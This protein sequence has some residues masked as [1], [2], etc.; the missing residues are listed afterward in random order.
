MQ[1]S[2][3]NRLSKATMLTACYSYMSSG[4]AEFGKHDSEFLTSN[5]TLLEF[6][7]PNL[8]GTLLKTGLEVPGYP[9][10]Q[11]RF[12]YQLSYLVKVVRVCPNHSHV[13]AE[14][15]LFGVCLET[16]PRKAAAVEIHQHLNQNM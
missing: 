15:L 2:I 14:M 10:H 11:Y 8:A 13:V 12:L 6:K 1:G 9:L 4:P 16:L 3:Q 7:M 5:M